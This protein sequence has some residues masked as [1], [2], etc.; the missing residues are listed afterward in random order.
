MKLTAI[1]LLLVGCVVQQ[2]S[3]G[4]RVIGA[5]LNI[6]QTAISGVQG[7]LYRPNTYASII[8]QQEKQSSIISELQEKVKK[9]QEPSS[10]V[11]QTLSADSP[12]VVSKLYEK[13][14]EVLF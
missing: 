13:N 7:Q 12:T 3:S 1:T 6:A 14:F 11:V 2:A 4:Q 9:T 8:A 10:I 5:L